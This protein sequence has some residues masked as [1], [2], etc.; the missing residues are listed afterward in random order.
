MKLR[1][2][3]IAM[4]LPAL[5]AVLISTA[6]VLIALLV[7]RHFQDDVVVLGN[8]SGAENGILVNANGVLPDQSFKS[9]TNTIDMG[10]LTAA[11]SRNEVIAFTN[12]RPVA[13]APTV[14][15]T[16]GSDTVELPFADEIP[17]SITI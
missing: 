2:K 5:T 7:W 13:I 8:T 4:K 1:T 6:V 11:A 14:N 15:W 10:R 12:S 3:R 17:I 9:G 16:S